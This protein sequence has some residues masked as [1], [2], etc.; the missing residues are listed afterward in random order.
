MKSTNYGF[1]L[2][3]SFILLISCGFNQSGKE[4]GN[5]AV[6]SS[7][8][9]PAPDFNADSAYYYIEKQT[10][11]GPRV[12]NT[13]A[14]VA[15][16]NY[17]VSELKRFGAHVI[18][19]KAELKAYNGEILHARNI[20]GSFSVTNK[21]RILLF[22]H[23]DSRPYADHD[24]D[25]KNHQVPISGANDGASG[26]GVL[27]EI[28]RQV[29]MKYPEMGM[30]IILFDAEDYGTPDFY[31]GDAGEDTWCLGSQYWAVNPHV[32]GYTARFGILLDMVGAKDAFFMKEGFSR[33][34]ANR[35]VEKIWQTAR[36][37]GYGKYFINENGG[38]ITDDHLYVNRLAN[39][40]SVDIIQMDKNSSSGFY[41][42]WHTV[43]DTM[44]YIDKETL[45]AV[46]QTIL[47]VI[48]NEK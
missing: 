1:F 42:H 36:Q 14:H 38:Y 4:N 17:L 8:T 6:V 13:A 28:A 30:D 25:E 11:F 34:Y 9:S 33:E 26:V 12:P 37:L 24:P 5:Q 44:E 18:E 22:A 32:K 3:L 20:I 41:E 43:N 15:C 21:D 19:Q 35:Y 46:G 47:E 40:P 16:S 23:W 29:G 7:K 10:T 45:K 39:I 27:L 2:C 31:K 48:Y